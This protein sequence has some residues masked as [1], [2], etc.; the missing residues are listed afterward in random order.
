MD[1]PQEE[2]KRAAA[3]RGASFVENGMVVGLGSGSTA[4]YA[5][6]FLGE[7]VRAGLAVRAIPTSSR[8]KQLAEREGIPLIDFGSVTELDL[9]IDGADEV[10]PQLDLIKGGGGALVREKVVASASHRLIIVADSSK[11]VRVL[12]A[13][14][15]PVVVVPFAVPRIARLIGE[16]GASVALR[17]DEAKQPFITDDGNHLL[18]CRFDPIPD[19]RALASRL[20]ETPGIVDHGLFLDMADLVVIARGANVVELRRERPK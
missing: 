8:S 12:G 2:E 4:A 15:L 1:S 3:R 10:D 14:P 9:T 17:T 7:R 19:A 13:F 6:E 18:D 16:M 11:Q 5:I 20:G